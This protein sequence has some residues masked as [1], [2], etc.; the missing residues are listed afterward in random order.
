MLVHSPRKEDIMSTETNKSILRTAA[1]AFNRHDT[2]SGWFGIHDPSVVAHGLG[3]KPLDLE[4]LK[5]FYGALWSAF[6]DL[7]ITVEDMI[8]EAD[9]VSWRL[10]VTGTHKADFNG[11]PPTGTRVTFTAQYIFRF[12]D[13]RIA[14]RWTNLDQ[15]GVLMQLGAI[16]LPA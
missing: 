2:G 4:G 9:K 10:L 5:R 14:E 7:R 3:P 15:L 6:P 16:H 12:R 8:A 11:I 13:G 1:E